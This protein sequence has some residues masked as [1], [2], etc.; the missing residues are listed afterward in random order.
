MN[1]T[2]TTNW[3]C[4]KCGEVRSSRHDEN[5]CAKVAE[6]KDQSTQLRGALQ[7]CASY[8]GGN[9]DATAS[10]LLHVMVADEVSSAVA[11]LK[12]SLALIGEKAV[13]NWD[14]ATV[15]EVDNLIGNYSEGLKV[16]FA[17]I[18]RLKK[19]ALAAEAGKQ[20]W[21]RQ[22]LG[23]EL[24]N[25]PN[26][27]EL[28]EE[29]ER[30]KDR[31]WKLGKENADLS[32]KN[33]RL[34]GRVKDGWKSPDVVCREL[35]AAKKEIERLQ[36]RQ[37]PEGWHVGKLQGGETNVVKKDCGG[38]T[39]EA[40]YTYESWDFDGVSECVPRRDLIEIDGIKTK[41]GESHV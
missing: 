6:L 14:D 24:E 35:N 28:L 17:E 19:E 7:R 21:M 41:A 1:E 31:L 8:V 33:E 13:V 37:L 15:G 27:A 39:A 9:V 3:Q 18:E 32:D 22:A 2:Q 20:Y 29:I 34:E 26:A 38:Y 36:K 16:H 23:R 5:M 12:L 4:E 30:L 40:F 25:E 10:H 11:K